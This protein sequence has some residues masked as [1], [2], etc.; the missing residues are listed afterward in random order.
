MGNVVVVN[1][2]VHQKPDAFGLGSII[3]L[4]RRYFRRLRAKKLSVKFSMIC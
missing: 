3:L 2:C 1:T 4:I